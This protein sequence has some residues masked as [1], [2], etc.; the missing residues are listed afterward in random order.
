[1]ARIELQSAAKRP[2][3]PVSAQHHLSQPPCIHPA[4]ACRFG[5][6]CRFD[7]PPEFAVRLNRKGLPLRPGEAICTF[8][9]RFGTCKFGPACKFHHPEPAP[10]R[11]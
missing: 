7:H 3:V 1:M 2:A 8:Y 9:E 6:T 5:P 10:L 11:S 4:G